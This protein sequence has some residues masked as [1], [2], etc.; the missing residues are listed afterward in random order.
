MNSVK[1]SSTKGSRRFVLGRARLEK[2]SAVEGIRTTVATRKM[3]AEFDRDE[4]TAAQR[5]RAIFEKHVRKG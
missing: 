3:F 2:I 5:R 1:S 4:L